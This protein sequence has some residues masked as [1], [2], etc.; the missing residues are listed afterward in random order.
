MPPSRQSPESA[1]PFRASATAKAV[2]ALQGRVDA[3]AATFGPFAR[4]V[5]GLSALTAAGQVSFVIALPILSRLYAPSDFGLFTIYLSIVNIGGPIMGLKFESALYAARTRQEAGTTLVLSLVTM[6]VMSSAV[7]LGLILFIGQLTGL[8]NS[9]L[10]SMAW[11]LPVGLL[12]AGLWSASSAWAI[13]AEAVSTLGLARLAQPAAMT[14]LQLSAGLILP[15]GGIGLIGAHLL[16]HIGY[17]SFIFWRTLER[18]DLATL[19]PTRWKNVLQRAREQRGFP[20]YVLPAQVSYLAVSNLPPLLL[21]A[22]FGAE[23]AGHCGV[24]YRLVAAPLAIASLPLGAIFTSVASRT[25]DLSVVMPLARKVFLANL[26]VVSIPIL[27]FGAV[28]P[29]IVPAVLGDRW[30]ITG[31]VIAAFALIGAAQSLATPFSEVTS[32]FR[33][34]AL[35][36]VIEFVPASLVVASICLGGLKHWDPIETIWTMSAAG[37]V[38]SLLGLTLLWSRMR[39]MIQRAAVHGCS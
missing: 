17:S 26:F 30:I 38:S 23:I 32:I 27:L 18:K 3:L 25:P 2:H 19:L 20:M 16:S 14:A 4:K 39:A 28:A 6:I 31:Q 11:V 7:A 5:M 15:L 36:F 1:L 29:K 12:L 35:R 8:T 37:A 21:S 24:A 34:Q 9:A 10:R 13:K 33:S 22:F